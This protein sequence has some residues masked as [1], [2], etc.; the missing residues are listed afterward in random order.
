[1]IIIDRHKNLEDKSHSKTEVVIA[2]LLILGILTIYLQTRHHEFVVYDDRTYITGNPYV[3]DGLSSEGL[4]WAFSFTQKEKTYWHPLTWLSHMLDIQLFGSNAGSHLMINILLHSLNTLLLLHILRRMTGKL[5]A[6]ALVAALF[7]IHP[8]NVESVAWVAARKNLLSTLFWMLTILAYIRYAEKPGLGRYGLTLVSLFFGLLSKPMLVTLPC[9]LLLLDFWPLRR[10]SFG[11]GYSTNGAHVSFSRLLLEKTPM[12]MLSVASIYL[13]TFSLSNYGDLVTAESVN[14]RLR[15]AN[16]LISYVAYIY[17][18]LGPVKL[19]CY[20]PFPLEIPFWKSAGAFLILSGISTIALKSFRQYPFFLIG[21]LW[22]IG[23]LFPVIGLVQAGLWPALADRFTYVPMIGI[24]LIIAWGISELS[25][26]KPRTVILSG[27]S[28]GAI[29]LVFVIMSHKQVGYWK[30]S[31]TLFNHAIKITKDNYLS[32]YALAYAHEQ[33]GSKEEAIRHYGAALEI[34]PNEADVHYNLAVLLTSK[35][36]YQA[37]TSHYMH[38]L[39]IKPD[40]A[41]VHNNLGNVYFHQK[42]WPKAIKHYK[43]A[44]QH[45]PGYGKA[46]KNL[47]ATMFRLG[48]MSEAVNRFKEALR[49]MPED[50]QTQKYLLMAI[51][52]LGNNTA[53]TESNSSP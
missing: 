9:V 52:Q 23:T 47:G 31:I 14:M 38:A 17:K 46:H 19:T 45:E 22:Y 18:V 20:Y 15:I 29:L 41:Q 1:M 30:N 24:F 42:D 35:K 44:I 7:A 5:W 2:L 36:Q 21:W 33:K 27:I 11:H 26:V 39:R 16:A 34:N 50:A 37:A 10:Y 43:Y 25:K 6:P 3:L 49:I 12:I 53:V 13:S 8:L 48:R 32:H 4:K 51:N 40:D 28:I